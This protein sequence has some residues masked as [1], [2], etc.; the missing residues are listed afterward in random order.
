MAGGTWKPKPPQQADADRFEREMDFVWATFRQEADAVASASIETIKQQN[1]AGG[2][3]W[4]NPNESLREVQKAFVMRCFAMI[5]GL[6][7]HV[8]GGAAWDKV[9]RAR[10]KKIRA[11]KR[12]LGLPEPSFPSPQTY[13]MVRFIQHYMGAQPT[14]ARLAIEVY[15]HM[16]MHE[17]ALRGVIDGEGRVYNW[18]LGW[19]AAPE[20]HFR[21]RRYISGYTA[22]QVDDLVGEFGDDIYGKGWLVEL[23]TLNLIADVQ[24]ASEKYAADMR[25]STSLHN[26]FVRLGEERW[27][28]TLS[29]TPRL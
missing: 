11:K 20:H 5:D 6:S 9:Y 17:G 16:L 25:V 29:W 13:R 27:D 8:R 4:Q 15:R 23:G 1:D 19:N 18:Y 7:Q 28:D 24:R 14:E 10:T 22:Q 26:A 3:R 2:Q 21:V 12:S